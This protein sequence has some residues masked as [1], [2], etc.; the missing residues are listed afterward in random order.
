[1]RQYNRYEFNGNPYKILL[2]QQQQQ[3]NCIIAAYYIY[4]KDQPNGIWFV[5]SSTICLVK[6]KTIFSS[7]GL[8]VGT[9]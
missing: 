2:R 5:F 9:K 6:R 8:G 3:K 1:M 4:V 7:W